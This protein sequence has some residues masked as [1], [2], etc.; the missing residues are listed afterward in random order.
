MPLALAFV[1]ALAVLPIQSSGA[2]AG[3]AAC[4]NLTRSVAIAPNTSPAV[5]AQC[6]QITVSVGGSSYSTPPSCV[7]GY[8]QQLET[9]WTCGPAAEGLHCDPQ[10]SKATHATYSDGAC[11]TA[12]GLTNGASWSDWTSVPANLVSIISGLSS[13]V[14]PKRTEDWDYSAKVVACRQSM[15]EA[16]IFNG[17]GQAQWMGNPNEVIPDVPS[18]NPFS[19]AYEVAAESGSA[20]SQPV[21]QSVRA[22]FGKLAG[23]RFAVAVTV[24]HYAPGS[25]SPEHQSFAVYDGGMSADGLFDLVRSTQVYSDGEPAEILHRRYFDGEVLRYLTEGA[26]EGSAFSRA[27]AEQKQLWRVELAPELRPVYAWLRNPFQIPTFESEPYVEEAAS[28]GV[29]ISRM[30]ESGSTVFAGK[31]YFV[32]PETLDVPI[33][34]STLVLD[35]AGR[36]CESTSYSDFRQIAPGV[37]RP[38]KQECVLYLDRTSTGTRVRVS[39][40]FR[41]ARALAESEV[42]QQIVGAQF[43]A[44]TVWSIWL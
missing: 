40:E 8:T 17:A 14:P 37:W 34:T 5:T 28:S 4:N 25:A 41:G 1:W 11:P 16:P 30:F 43:P 9:V 12:S 13:C 38:F 7:V 20:S 29:V 18:F 42:T 27:A 22:A 35:E 32:S 21:L 19:T 31:Q 24:E 3:A 44:D 23:A 6:T 10:G 15:A 26:G 33:V 36:T 39:H 2:G